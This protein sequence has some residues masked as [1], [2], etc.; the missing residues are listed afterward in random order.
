MLINVKSIL[1]IL[2]CFALIHSAPIE[3]K[4]A[5]EITDSQQVKIDSAVASFDK[6]LGKVTGVSAPFIIPALEL[7]QKITCLDS[8]TDLYGSA[9]SIPGEDRDIFRFTLFETDTPV[10]V[11]YRGYSKV[12][13]TEYQKD[14]Q[15]GQLKRIEYEI[16]RGHNLYPA[17]PV[18]DD[19]MS[20]SQIFNKTANGGYYL[21]FW[22]INFFHRPYIYVLKYIGNEKYVLI[23]Y[24]GHPTF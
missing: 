22:L 14:S 8:L 20:E 2:S 1:I 15:T 10:T 4:I 13:Q 7:Y 3:I 6:P 16:A 11:R 24:L 18:R 17:L 23:K 5:G 21:N 19:F 9:D 12:F